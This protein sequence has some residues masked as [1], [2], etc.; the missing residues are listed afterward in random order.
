VSE[1]LGCL[2][3]CAVSLDEWFPVFEGIY[4]LLVE[5]LLGPERRKYVDGAC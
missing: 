4:Y 3:S 1:V 2:A 5:G